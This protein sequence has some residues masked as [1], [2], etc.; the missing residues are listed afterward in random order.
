MKKSWIY[1][2]GLLFFCLA[3]WGYRKMTRKDFVNKFMKAAANVDL[4]KYAADKLA[5]LSSYESGDGGGNMA[6][7]GNNIFSL[8][9]GK[10]WKGPVQ[11]QK[12]T[13]NKFRVYPSYE[14]AI[15]D[16][17]DLLEGWPT[18]YKAASTAAKAGS[19]EQFAAAL[20]AAGYGDP[21]KTTYA[22]ELTDRYR[23]II[24]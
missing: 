2:A 13:G 16:F 8:Q 1:G 20:Q 7:P 17:I 9:A 18:N 11:V 5:A 23:S 4:R 14:A 21:G 15:K 19:M 12:S 10:Y 6:N 22:A 24:A 3:F